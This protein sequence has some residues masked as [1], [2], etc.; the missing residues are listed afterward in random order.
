MLAGHDGTPGQMEKAVLRVG[1]SGAGLSGWSAEGGSLRLWLRWKKEAGRE[2]AGH[3]SSVPPG[4]GQQD[5]GR[6]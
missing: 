3:S 1:G 5:C 2:G 6:C 4:P